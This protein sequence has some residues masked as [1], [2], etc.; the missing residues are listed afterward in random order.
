MHVNGW[1]TFKSRNCGALA[2]DAMRTSVTRV[3]V[4]AGGF[5]SHAAGFVFL[6]GLKPV[7]FRTVSWRKAITARA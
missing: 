5:V 2:G 6:Q 3:E 1:R 4:L 7:A